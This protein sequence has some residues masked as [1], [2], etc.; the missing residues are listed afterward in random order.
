MPPVSSQREPRRSESRPASGAT[1][2]ISAVIGRKAA[3]ALTG[4]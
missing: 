2:M 4:E 3:P 1:N